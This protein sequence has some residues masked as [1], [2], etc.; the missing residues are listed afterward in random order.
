MAAMSAISAP[1]WLEG[2]WRMGLARPE[3]RRRRGRAG[4]VGPDAAAANRAA[5]GPAARER[6]RTLPRALR[7]ARLAVLVAVAGATLALASGLARSAHASV[8]TIPTAPALAF[9]SIT[10]PFALPPTRA[11]RTA[12]AERAAAL[13]EPVTISSDA[14]GSAIAS[15]TY[16]SHALGWRDRYLVY[17]PPGY[18]RAAP[19]ATRSSTCCMATTS[20]PARSCGSGCSRH[21]TA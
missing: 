13:P 14:A 8:A 4:A 2:F 5:G 9:A 15:I 16:S 10:H 7:L 1:T 11:A 20:R 18:A 6:P 12:A 17:L 19:A 21:S 3:A